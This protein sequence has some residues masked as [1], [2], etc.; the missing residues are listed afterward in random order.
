MIFYFG[1][2]IISWRRP[3]W[4]KN[5]ESPHFGIHIHQLIA[6]IDLRV[7]ASIIAPRPNLPEVTRRKR[8]RTLATRERLPVRSR[9]GA[10]I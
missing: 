6:D 7:S 4:R 2:T 8:L 9:P 5:D 1:S 10:Q 3:V